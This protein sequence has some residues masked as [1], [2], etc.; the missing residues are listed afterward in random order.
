MTDKSLEQLEKD[1]WKEESDYPTSLVEKCYSYRKIPLNN[2][3]G[4]QIRLLISQNIGIRFLIPLAIDKLN[5]NILFEGDLYKGDLLEQVSKINE[6]YYR[7]N[8]EDIEKLKSLIFKNSDLIK[9]ELGEKKFMKI[10]NWINN[11]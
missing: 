2:L 5:Q 7:E 1:Y 8:P 6:S 3:N 4:E 10:V 9:D 11:N